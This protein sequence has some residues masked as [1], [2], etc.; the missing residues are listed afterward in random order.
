MIAQQDCSR[1]NVVLLGN[2]DD[3]LGFEHGTA[4][5]T[6]GAVGHNVNALLL[7]EIDDLVLRQSRMVLNLVDG[8]DNCCLGQQ[9]L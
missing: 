7:A 2:L 9:L 3:R 8:W 1:A 4:C 6:E 5:A